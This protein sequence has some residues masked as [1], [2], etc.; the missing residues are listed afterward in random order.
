MI[1]VDKIKGIKDFFSEKNA[2]T[3]KLYPFY[4]GNLFERRFSAY[5]RNHDL[6]RATY[7]NASYIHKDITDE[8]IATAKI[9]RK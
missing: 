2:I 4:G 7:K 9:V 6:L 5:L 3:E 8:E 1:D